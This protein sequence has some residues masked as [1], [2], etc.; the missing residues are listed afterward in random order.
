MDLVFV[1]DG[2]GSICDSDPNFDYGKDVTCDNW[3]FIL[4][5]VADF[6]A[7][8]DI[9]PSSTRIGLVTF[10]TDASVAWDI[11]KYADVDFNRLCSLSIYYHI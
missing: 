6:V 11:M 5:F 4:R 9:G 1:L 7:D 3:E 2:S 10:A 8:M